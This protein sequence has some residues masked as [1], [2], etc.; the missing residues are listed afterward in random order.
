MGPRHHITERHR[1]S[2][3]TFKN[4]IEKWPKTIYGG[5]GADS[6]NA[7]GSITH[8]HAAIRGLGRRRR[9]AQ[10]QQQEQFRKHNQ[11]AP[12]MRGRLESYQK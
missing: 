7:L 10:G 11:A 1:K 3:I 5:V 6:K 12:T 2:N 4:S 9:T 8:F